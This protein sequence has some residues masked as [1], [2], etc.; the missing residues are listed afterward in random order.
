MRYIILDNVFGC[1]DECLAWYD[2]AEAGERRRAIRSAIGWFLGFRL[3]D[4][5]LPGFGDLAWFLESEEK[6][7]LLLDVVL[8]CMADSA[9]GQRSTGFGDI[10]VKDSGAE[11]GEA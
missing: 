5:D 2:G 1:K 10:I 4:P 6:D 9:V 11:E 3:L 7:R 8:D